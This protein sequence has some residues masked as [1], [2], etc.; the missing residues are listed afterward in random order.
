MTQGELNEQLIRTARS[1]D[2]AGVRS[3]ID[4][5]ADV[6]IQDDL[7]RT[8]LI[9]A[10]REGCSEVLKLLLERGADINIQSGGGT[11]R[12]CMHPGMDIQILS[13]CFLNMA[14]I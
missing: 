6:N 10:A 12:L 14:Q 1:G 8:A 4:A 13:S 5:G 3:A 9:Y 2:T 7:G 11:L